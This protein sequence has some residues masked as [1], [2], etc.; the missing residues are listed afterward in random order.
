MTVATF[1]MVER[2][3]DMEAVA[4]VSRKAFCK[5]HKGNKG[6]QLSKAALKDLDRRQRALEKQVSKAEKK[7]AE[8][9]KQSLYSEHSVS[10]PFLQE[11][12]SHSPQA[13]SPEGDG[14]LSPA[15]P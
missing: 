2:S 9:E 5:S 7:Q 3:K 15:Q 11:Q 13:W 10:C 14:E 8:L 4:S 12:S 6:K 1:K